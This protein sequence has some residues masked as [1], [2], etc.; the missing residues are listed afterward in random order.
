MDLGVFWGQDWPVCLFRGFFPPE[1][2]KFLATPKALKE[3]AMLATWFSFSTARFPNR[4]RIVAL[5]AL[6]FVALC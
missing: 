5:A 2:G 3:Y 4:R 1:A 6:T